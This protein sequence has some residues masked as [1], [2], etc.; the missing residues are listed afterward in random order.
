M[1]VADYCRRYRKDKRRVE[2]ALKKNRVRGVVYINGIAD[3]PEDA[4]IDYYIPKRKTNI[5]IQD[6]QIYLLKALASFH[7]ID[8]CVLGLSER[9]FQDVVNSMVALNLVERTGEPDGVTTTGLK[10]TPSGEHY[11]EMRNRDLAKFLIEYISSG[12]TQGTL[13]FFE[14]KTS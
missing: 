12:I 5:T 8:A 2:K 13:S 11:A 1:N 7:Y 4:K 10:A 9:D 6:A 3:I 14:T